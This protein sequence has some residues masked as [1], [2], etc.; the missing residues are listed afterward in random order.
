[1]EL[2]FGHACRRKVLGPSKE[3]GPAVADRATDG[4]RNG[5]GLVGMA[6][7]GRDRRPRT[8]PAGG[9][10]QLCEKVLLASPGYLRIDP[11]H[12]VLKRFL[13]RNEADP[14]LLVGRQQ[15]VER[16]RVKSAD[17][18]EKDGLDRP[19]AEC[20][21]S[22]LGP[23]KGAKSCLAEAPRQRFHRARLAR[24]PRIHVIPYPI[25]EVDGYW[26]DPITGL[27][28]RVPHGFSLAQGSSLVQIR[29]AEQPVM[30]PPSGT[31]DHPLVAL[32]TRQ[33]PL[34]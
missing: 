20:F 16:Q 4:W 23:V 34:R 19:L 31:H 2:E 29:I 11:V 30:L 15:V 28:E 9:A 21:R 22:S 7:F 6:T 27:P 24:T 26:H 18:K 33:A 32:S 25:I 3:D 5:W 1:M 12:R 17:V 14:P 10:Q 8:R 13:H